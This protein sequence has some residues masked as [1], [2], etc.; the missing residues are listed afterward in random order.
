MYRDKS[1]R[2]FKLPNITR[3]VLTIAIRCRLPSHPAE[4]PTKTLSRTAQCAVRMTALAVFTRQIRHHSTSYN[5]YHHE[6]LFATHCQYWVVLP[7]LFARS[8]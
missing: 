4:Q 8:S 1:S 6:H 5:T 3:Y 7:L 2:H